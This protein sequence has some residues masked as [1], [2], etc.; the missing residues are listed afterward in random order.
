MEDHFGQQ[1]KRITHELLLDLL[2]G[3]ALLTQW[4]IVFLYWNKVPDKVPMHFNTAGAPD[5]YGTKYTLFLLPVISILLFLGFKAFRFIKFDRYHGNHPKEI[6]LKLYALFRSY[7][8]LT[9]AQTLLFFLL[10]LYLSIKI[11]AGD[12]NTLPNSVI[13]VYFGL[14]L[15]TLIIYGIVEWRMKKAFY[16]ANPRMKKEFF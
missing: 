14:I 6:S 7:L 2:S 1:N 10:L 3:T 15:L 4:I 13:V 16:K 8:S 9:A 11:A 12:L 5:G